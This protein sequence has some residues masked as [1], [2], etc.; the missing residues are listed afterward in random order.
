MKRA[1]EAKGLLSVPSPSQPST[2]PK[3]AEMSPTTSLMRPP[4][5]SS[6]MRPTNLSV[7]STET[8][9]LNDP[10]GPIKRAALSAARSKKLRFL[11][12]ASLA[13][14]NETKV[15]DITTDIIIPRERV[16]S[17]CS[18]DKDAL[19]DYLNEGDNSQEQEAELL[20][21]FQPGN[22]SNEKDDSL[23]N[24]NAN[25][26]NNNNKNKNND[27]NNSNNNTNITDDTATNT[28]SRQCPITNS[29]Y[30]MYGGNQAQP[31]NEQQQQQ[32]LPSSQEP[33]PTSTATVTSETGIVQ[34]PTSKKE[35]Q[36][37]ELRQYLQQNLQQ[38][39]SSVANTDKQMIGGENT[40]VST[41]TSLSNQHSA[42]KRPIDSMPQH[43][44]AASLAM[45]SS[46][47]QRNS[48]V[49]Q[50]NFSSSSDSSEMTGV[51][52]KLNV[53][54][55]Q[56]PP[57]HPQLLRS[58]S[59][60]SSVAPPPLQSPNS[61]R[62]NFSFVPISPG[63]QSPRVFMPQ[64]TVG[65]PIGN[66]GQN[67]LQGSPFVSP[68][69]TPAI[70]KPINKD[71]T[72]CLNSMQ[73]DPLIGSYKTAFSKP[74]GIK[75]EIS[76]SAPVSPS[77]TPHHFQFNNNMMASNYN[78]MALNP[79][80]SSQHQ[81]QLQHQQQQQ[82]SLAQSACSSMG[83]NPMFPMLE[84]RS[85]SVPLHCQS[86]AFNNTTTPNTAYSS[87]CNSIAQTPVPSEFAD[88]YDE[89]ILNILAETS[90]DQNIKLEDNDI[91]DLLDATDIG[92]SN[93]Q[94]TGGIDDL[95]PGL[96]N[97][98]NSFSNMSRSVPSTPL[99]ILGYNSSNG[100]TSTMDTSTVMQSVTKP[101]FDMSRSVPTTPLIGANHTNTPFRYSPEH[102]GDYLINGNTVDIDK[103]DQFFTSPQHH[104]VH[105][106][107]SLTQTSTATSILPDQ[108]D[109][110]STNDMELSNYNDVDDSIMDGTDLLNSL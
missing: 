94:N 40:L 109:L 97:R 70:R 63:P 60:S 18:L 20:Q 98:S 44:A 99:P 86:P 19:D 81:H 104:L 84:S 45:L 83:T 26:N 54:V 93:I 96:G 106:T 9:D 48:N 2:S 59:A 103:T 27:N 34:K 92:S 29:N 30:H 85:Q 1:H 105:P 82:Q 47:H 41:A 13:G 33:S 66:L 61:R 76:A 4:A 3:P 37:N 42:W 100:F 52:R 57:N 31:L 49:K 23:N 25:S 50:R 36:I 101:T 38:P 87:A 17:I 46:T 16:I 88:F 68:R 80:I 22:V 10:V 69:A 108:S 56:S 75:N 8:R 24:S 79:N 39:P 78:S 6:E 110:L 95:L 15:D 67:Q 90:V 58:I 107:Q 89:N 71:L 35:E 53:N 14:M 5:Y 7:N 77:I 12:H 91:P 11:K 62:K 51:K 43:S 64:S 21:Y 28:G 72:T 32:S 65:G 102:R 74:S 55:D 73:G